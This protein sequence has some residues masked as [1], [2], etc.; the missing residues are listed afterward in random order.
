MADD[1]RT[2]DKRAAL[3][4]RGCLHHHPE[5][6]R[7][8]LFTSHEFFDPDDLVQVKYEMLRRVRLEGETVHRA[9]ADFGLSRPSFYAAQERFDQ[10]GLVG[11]VPDKPGPKQGHKLSEE[12]LDFLERLTA[13]ESALRA[14]DLAGRLRQRFGVEVHPRSIERALNRR[15]KKNSG[16]RR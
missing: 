10:E 8:K 14:P 11:L 1:P 3:R 5:R 4:Q 6:V 9:A 12:I 2:R 7:D 13:E 16:R 15:R